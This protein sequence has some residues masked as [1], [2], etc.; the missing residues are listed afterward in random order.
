MIALGLAALAYNP[1]P[2]YEV[3]GAGD[4]SANGFYVFFRRADDGNSVMFA[5]KIRFELGVARRVP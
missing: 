5:C 2:V 4:V 1:S 3:H